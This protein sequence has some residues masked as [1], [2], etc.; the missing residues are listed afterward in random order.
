[1][2]L[3]WT[4]ALT[5]GIDSTC[6]QE[7]RATYS[8]AN[9]R[10]E[11]S[12]L[13]LESGEWS[14]I[15]PGS[16]RVTTSLQQQKSATGVVETISVPDESSIERVI[17][18]WNGGRGVLYL[19]SATFLDACEDAIHGDRSA[20]QSVIDAVETPVQIPLLCGAFLE[21]DDVVQLVDT[22]TDAD[23]H[24]ASMIH[25]YRYPILRSALVNATGLSVTSASDFEELVGG[26]DS[27]GSIGSVSVIDSVA[28]AMLTIHESVTETKDLL[29]A[30]GYDPDTFEQREDGRFFAC[31]LAHAVMTDGVSAARG[32]VMQ[33]RQHLEGNYERKKIEA[34]N[35]PHHERGKKW[36]RLICAA[37]RQ[38]EGEFIY[39]LANALY[40]TGHSVRSDSRVQELLYRAAS[41]VVERIDLPELAGWAKF[42]WH[43][44]T[45]HRLRSRN[46]FAAAENR[47]T[48]ARQVAQRYSH[49]PEWQ[50]QYNEVVVRA[51]KQ[52]D[53][54]NQETA[55]KT[56]DDGIETLLQYDLRPEAATRVVHHLKGQHCEIAAETARSSDLVEARSLLTE[57]QD[58]YDAI[59]FTR[60]RNRAKRKRKHM[61]RSCREPPDSSPDTRA[62]HESG[63][64]ES[65]STVGTKQ[66]T[67]ESPTDS[68]AG[69]GA[70]PD[71]NSSP[72]APESGDER[73]KE[74]SPPD[75]P[76]SGPESFPEPDSYPELND[77]LTPHD[78]SKTGT[79]DIMSGPDAN[80]TES[81]PFYTEGDSERD[82]Y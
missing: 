73:G 11:V 42:E 82:Q 27:I 31:V 74:A 59:D 18:E 65:E 49:L 58:H 32:Y 45:G 60:S 12:A 69:D 14:V 72:P 13:T 54:D 34:R 51:H 48:E 21:L 37:A 23:R 52:K 68:T 46:Q 47:F 39:V 81:N 5:D 56:I 15:T 10:V 35:A 36:R 3:R 78:E 8:R 38:S 33:R 70:T 6:V 66:P 29:A 62:S 25:S 76:R 2:V 43:V 19:P 61:P 44:A 24:T 80:N 75:P 20:A 67:S 28:D 53:A 30:L 9:Y 1:M 26:F 63:A 57:A 50:A 64:S 4:Q 77:S 16:A 79:G 17:V 22:V 7:T 71:K 41:V 55:L 40:W